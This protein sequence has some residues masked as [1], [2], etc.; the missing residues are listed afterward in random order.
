MSDLILMGGGA[1]PVYPIAGF[2]Y[3]IVDQTEVEY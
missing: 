2:T 3:I 1:G